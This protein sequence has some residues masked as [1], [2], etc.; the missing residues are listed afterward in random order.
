MSDVR[1]FDYDQDL[2]AVKRIWREVGWI[3]SEKDAAG[4][5]DFFSV[6]RTRVGLINDQPECSVHTVQ[7]TVQLNQTGLSL[8]AVTAVTTSRIAR[9]KAFARR[10]TAEQL[11][12]AHGQGAQ[13]AAL[14]MFDQGFYDQ[15]GFGTGAYEHLFTIDP[16]TLNVNAKVPAP[17]RFGMEH[18]SELHAA[19]LKRCKVHGAIDLLEPALFKAELSFADQ[20]TALG[21]R[22][23][24]GAI[25]HFLVLENKGEHGPDRVLMWAYQDTEQLMQLLGLLKGLGDQI[26]SVKLI[27]PPQLQ[28]QA[29]LKRPFRQRVMTKD[30]EHANEAKTLAWWQMR[31][32]DVPAGVAALH[33]TPVSTEFIAHIDDPLSEYAEHPVC[34]GRYRIVLGERCYAERV[35]EA[36]SADLH[37]GIGAFSRWITGVAPASSLALTDDFTLGVELA[38]E[39]DAAVNLPR[40]VPGWDF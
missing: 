9:G 34:G 16:S 21:Y 40:P 22:D 12:H 2:A 35:E 6:G 20:F 31:L 37:C 11:I 29:L 36:A 23:A 5:D 30:S 24:N 33:N 1:D 7:G 25:S 4:L 38:G 28:L 3:D 17:L 15:L 32:L 8:C 27:E 14:G 10:L 39:L 18:A 13:A 19:M 26:Y